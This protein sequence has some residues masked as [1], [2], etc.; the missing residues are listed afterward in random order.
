VSPAA[1]PSTVPWILLRGLTREARHWGGFPQQLGEAFPGASVIC[2]DLPGNGRLNGRASPPN[3]EAMADYC[4]AELAKLDIAAP[5]RVLAMSLG[6]MVAVA[7]AQRH[8]D[9]VAAAVLI[10]TSLRPF[11]PFYRRMRPA[12][13]PRLLR[14]FGSRASDREMETAILELTTRLQRNPAAVIE[15]WLHWRRQ[16]PVSRRNALIQLLAAARYLA[17]R[18]PPLGHLLLLAGAGDAL[19]DPRCS[20]QLAAAWGAP[21]AVHPEAGHDLPLDDEA[22]VLAQIGTWLESTGAETAAG[23]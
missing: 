18:Q 3:V 4:H 14:L 23:Q 9:D 12:N 19:V 21:I 16:N 20:L 17:P 15:Q 13:Y 2:L 11:S 10:N 5:C 22:W 8:P 7:W 1:V 6:A